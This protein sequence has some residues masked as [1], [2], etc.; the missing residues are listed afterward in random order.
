[1]A[2]V[3]KSTMREIL[4]EV[5]IDLVA[6]IRGEL[7]RQGHVNTGRLRDSIGYNISEFGGNVT[8]TVL[9]DEVDYASAINDGFIPR[10]L[11]S[12]Y[13]IEDWVKQR[14]IQSNNPKIAN[15]KNPDKALAFAIAKAIQDEGS[16]TRGA[17]R[18]SRNGFRRGFATRPF[19]SRKNSI[20]SKIV[21]G[22]TVELEI[23]LDSITKQI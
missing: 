4:T 18:F 7:E 2:R 9:A 14:G 15:S 8:L 1:M 6:A 5:G 21:K 10:S 16:P 20:H 22:M 13:A 12:V 3:S 19:G 23:S 11:P 17:F